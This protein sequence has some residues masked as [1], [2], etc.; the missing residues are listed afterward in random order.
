MFNE[1]RNTFLRIFGE[2]LLNVSLKGCEME[3]IKQKPLGSVFELPE[4]LPAIFHVS[5][6]HGLIVRVSNRWLQ[7]FG[8]ERHEVIGRRSFDFLAEDAQTK[9]RPRYEE[10]LKTGHVDD[11]GLEFVA[12]DGAI[13]SCCLSAS[14]LFDE[15]GEH[16]GAVAF[17]TLPD[18][19]NVIVERL[20]KKSFRLQSYLEGTNAGT[21]EWNVQTGETRFNLRWA[22]IVGYTLDEL[23]PTTIQTWL[24][25]AHPDDLEKSEAAL[26]AH[27][28]GETAF[29]DIE[30][31]MKHKDGHWVW[32]HDRG[33]VF[34]RTADGAP[35]WM[36]GTH[37]AIDQLKQS[38]ETENRLKQLFERTGQ[39]AGVGGW[40][41]DLQ[42]NELFWTAETRRIHGVSED[43]LPSV[44][45][46]ISF[47]A[48]EARQTVADAVN[49]AMDDGTPWDLELPF[50]RMNGERIWV[51]AV[52]QAEFDE[53]NKP[54]RLFGA[55]QDI[56]ERVVKDEE[57]RA[58]RDWMQLA[59]SSGGVGLWSLDI[60]DGTVTW[61]DTMIEHFAVTD[62]SKP[63]TLAAWLA[64]LPHAEAAKFKSQ[65]K[66]L[67]SGSPRIDIE[68][69]FDDGK[70]LSHSLKL[71]GE[72]YK[73]HDGQLDRIHGACFDLTPER[74]LL[75]ELQE[76]TSKLSV[77]MSSIGDGV[78][79]TDRDS[80][81][82]WL[83]Q[84]A[85]DLSGWTVE[86][87]IGRPS[88]EVFAV[89]NETTGAPVTD[90]IAKC[91]K[92][93][94][95][96]TLEPNSVLRQ[97]SGEETP[98]DDSAAPIIG[99]DGRTAGAVI[100]F[101]DVTEQR[102]LSRDIEY[103]ATHDLLT[104]LLNRN[105]FQQR[106]NACLIDPIAR[107]SSFLFFIDLDH[108]KRVND[109]HGHDTGDHL[110]RQIA[111]VLSGFTDSKIHAARQGGDEFVVI[112]HFPT[113]AKA[114]EF[115][116]T[117]LSAIN[118]I[119]VADGCARIGA[120]IG[121]TDISI[122]APDGSEH[123]R[124]ADIAAYSAK[125]AGRN[126][127]CVWSTDDDAMR[128]V[129]MQ[130]SLI[131]VIERANQNGSWEIH[132]QRI[133]P[134]ASVGGLGELRELLIRLPGPDG[135]LIAPEQF[136]GAAERYGLMPNIDLWMFRRCLEIAAAAEPGVTY[137]VN[138]SPASLSSRSFQKDFLAILQTGTSHQ[139]GRV[140]IEVTETSIVENMEQ[141]SSFLSTLREYGLSVA[142]D[143]FGAG[144]SS[145][146]YFSNLPADYLK[147]DGS[148]IRNYH[149]PVSFASLEC[150]IKMA[151]VAGLQT[152]AEH[153]ESEEMIEALTSLGI[154]YL[155]GFAIERPKVAAFAA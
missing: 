130:L 60:V 131:D 40:E 86:E 36:Y 91:L 128:D 25:F 88:S 42:T 107:N 90:P 77:T 96:V 152:V 31:R 51:R 62:A 28:S 69:D 118:S 115:A 10:V 47:Y 120:S 6:P 114:E 23:G 132:E 39:V 145:F 11:L 57:L 56:S 45:D 144:A 32:V 30:A 126:Q 155:Q 70:G 67:I 7:V 109:T 151:H 80:R 64:L 95:T 94:E 135:K 34:T 124:R 143:D 106:L 35:E 72:A 134:V 3:A 146:R 41:L 21:W 141:M 121:V 116:G 142:I 112:G 46:G 93:G 125:A 110:L 117:M 24:D 119:H 138:L 105:E 54:A 101:R 79:T 122:P 44:A 49:Q 89:Y 87:A 52:G 4:D 38:Q 61:D 17:I 15:D 1:R 97:R 29:Y 129:A 154:D 73:D 20:R 18:D 2:I 133:V 98:V 82:T 71:M 102:K 75:V 27:W 50:D 83:N 66:R 92:V 48:P 13:V 103:R 12:K 74:S 127:I 139:L 149:D 84:V 26:N 113:S 140:C 65:V 76:Q 33:R 150:F 63:H 5:D 100:V 81:V 53:R 16:A 85:A 37:F 148:F 14:K 55:F 136:L 99:P 58:T 104:G 111:E 19:E 153:V 123:M 22:E 147:I 9:V 8:Y 78:I 108:F 43:F 137:S 59:S 68:I